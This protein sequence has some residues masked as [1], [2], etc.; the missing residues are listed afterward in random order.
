MKKLTLLCLS[1]F[2]IAACNDGTNKSS[3]QEENTEQ[4]K[5]ESDV[6]GENK[7][8]HG[9]LTSAGETW[10]ELL[11]DCIRVFEVGQRLHPVKTSEG[12]AVISAFAV[13]NADQSK[14]ELFLPETE[15]VTVLDQ[16]ED[17]LYKNEVY[18]YNV[19]TSELYI[20]GEKAYTGNQ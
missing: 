15:S 1:L 12:E 9:C 5:T 18:T 17:Q 6:V 11:Q 4:S 13:F 8:T 7:D 14:V 16:A 3:I 10:S 2:I 20:S 19:E